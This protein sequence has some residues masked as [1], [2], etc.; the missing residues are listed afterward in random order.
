[1]NR[2][3]ILAVFVTRDLF[4]SV[5]SIVPLALALAFGIIAF[6]Y[7]MDQA[8]FLTVGGLGIGVICFVTTVLLASRANRASSYLLLARLHHRAE[9]L[10]ALMMSGLGITALLAVMIAGGNLLTGRLILEFPSVVWVVPTWLPLWLLAAALA[11]PLS[12]L[13]GR[14]G[15]HV[16]GYAL[17]VAL[18][19]A[20]D[21]KAWLTAR[22]LDWLAR[23]V[24]TI[25]WPV[26]TL[27]SHAS[28]GNHN[29]S[30]LLAGAL[31]LAY[32]GLLFGLATTLFEDKD[33]LWSE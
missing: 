23:V 6:E 11:L 27:L 31:T 16:A 24:D 25:L 10:A 14:G 7:G 18:L 17:V 15:S 21:R 1:M 13:V 4:R 8:Q 3:W 26:S 33:L 9:L 2:I 19:V 28:A 22:G 20:N 5:A 29:S 32:A 12:A 30:Y